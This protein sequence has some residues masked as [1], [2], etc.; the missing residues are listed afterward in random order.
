[1]S[2]LMTAKETAEYLGR[3]EWK[4]YEMARQ[5]ELPHIKFGRAI[6]FRKEALEAWMLSQEAASIKKDIVE[7]TEQPVTKNELR[8]ISRRPVPGRRIGGG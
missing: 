3:S 6:S 1:M 8:V 7:N 4:I 2:Q 5:K